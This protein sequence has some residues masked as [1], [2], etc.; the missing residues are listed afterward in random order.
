MRDAMNKDREQVYS[1]HRSFF[2][3]LFCLVLSVAA[4]IIA[5]YGNQLVISVVPED[6]QRIYHFTTHVG[7]EW[8]Y[9]YKHSVQQTIC[10]EYFKINGP[11]NMVMTYTK[12][13][14]YGVGLPC[15]VDDGKFTQTEDGHFILE[16]NRPYKDIQFRTQNIPQPRLFISGEEL[17]I[18]KIYKSGSLVV[19]SVDKRYK[20]WF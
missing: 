12:F 4:C 14:S 2:R 19:V 10:E 16:M 13:Q 6:G 20:S 9:T 3:I 5:W 11:R 1:G 7:D 8:H 15:Y 17:P 18:Y